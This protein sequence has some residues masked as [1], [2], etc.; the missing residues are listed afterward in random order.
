MTTPD[1]HPT[2]DKPAIVRKYSAY[3]ARLWIE[4]AE[5]ALRAAKKALDTGDWGAAAATSARALETVGE[6]EQ[7]LGPLAPGYVG[8]FEVAEVRVGRSPFRRSQLG[9]GT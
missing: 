6:A 1:S 2:I 5:E 9:V 7:L 3:E 8:G 4:A